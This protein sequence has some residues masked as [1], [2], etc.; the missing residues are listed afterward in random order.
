MKLSSHIDTKQKLTV[1]LAKKA[2]AKFSEIGMSYIVAYDTMP[3]TNID[4]VAFG[5]DVHDHEGAD[6]L[7]IL[8]GIEVSHLILMSFSY[9]FTIIH[10]FHLQQNLKLEKHKI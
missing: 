2:I 10:L 4:D 7:L 3:V 1:C 9:W 5:I 8:H 6:T